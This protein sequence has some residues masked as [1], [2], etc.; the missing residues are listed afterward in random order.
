MKD[1][2][3]NNDR[4]GFIFLIILVAWWRVECD[5][6]GTRMETSLETIVMSSPGE[7]MVA[8][9]RMVVIKEGI[10]GWCLVQ[11]TEF[12]DVYNCCGADTQTPVS[13]NRCWP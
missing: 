10:G 4:S 1:V 12:K 7:S 13:Q 8:W 11:V 6:K 2:E 9:T 5:G 3:K